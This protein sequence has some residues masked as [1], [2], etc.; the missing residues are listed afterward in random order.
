MPEASQ[1]A[2]AGTRHP[3]TDRP[4]ADAE[5]GGDLLLGPALLAEVPRVKS[6]GFFPIAG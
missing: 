2:L 4:F 3:L 6:S 1:S 5:S